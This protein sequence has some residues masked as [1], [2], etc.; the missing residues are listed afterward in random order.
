MNFDNYFTAQL[1]IALGLIGLLYPCLSNEKYPLWLKCILT[2]FCIVLFGASCV[3]KTRRIMWR[4]V[5][6]FG[7]I[8]GS[9][10]VWIGYIIPIALEI[11][12]YYDSKPTRI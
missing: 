2:I 10:F 11:F 9:P 6:Q 7:T 4:L 8:I 5:K 3:P 12:Q 1:G